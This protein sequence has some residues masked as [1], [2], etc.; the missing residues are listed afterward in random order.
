MTNNLKT[1][2]Y[3]LNEAINND[4]TF[5][6]NNFNLYSGTIYP[7]PVVTVSI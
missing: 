2:K 4:P 1:N 5:D 6:T 7:L 3:Q